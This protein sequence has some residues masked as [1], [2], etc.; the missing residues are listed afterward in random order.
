[1]FKVM[2]VVA[3]MIAVAVSP[4]H[5]QPYDSAAAN[6]LGH[7][8][9][10]FLRAGQYRQALE[11]LNSSLKLAPPGS[12]EVSESLYF[13]GLAY[14]GLG[15]FQSAYL[16]LHNTLQLR[17]TP[18]AQEALDRVYAKINSGTGLPSQNTSPPSRSQPASNRLAG[19]WIALQQTPLAPLSGL[20]PTF[21][22]FYPNGQVLH[23]DPP[24]GGI[25]APFPTERCR[26]TDCGTYSAS[27]TG[28]SIRW[29]SG[30]VYDLVQDAEG[31]LVRQNVW[32][33]T[34]RYRRRD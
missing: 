7:Q 18:G 34:I 26:Y 9:V 10:Q 12:F 24:P 22:T 5:G 25:N 6:S 27:R 8:G 17:Q 16:D 29:N 14:E 30:E 23:E 31:A 11:V 2:L 15:D 1:M 28:V 32:N 3:A 20:A 19:V 13:R 4:S 21:L 33:A